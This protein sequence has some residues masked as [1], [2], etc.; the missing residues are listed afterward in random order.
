[1]TVSPRN[2]LRTVT[3]VKGTRRIRVTGRAPSCPKG[4]IRQ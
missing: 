2:A 3:C 4:F 1:V